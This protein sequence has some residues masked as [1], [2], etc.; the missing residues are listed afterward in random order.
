V[1]DSSTGKDQLVFSTAVGMESATALR[2]CLEGSMRTEAVRWTAEMSEM[3]QWRFSCLARED[4]ASNRQ[5]H[6]LE[7][8]LVYVN[9]NTLFNLPS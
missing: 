2:N 6:F 4:L 9:P 5:T 1:D 3:Q 7:I 8:P